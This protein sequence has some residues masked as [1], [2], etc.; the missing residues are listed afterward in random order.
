MQDF[1]HFSKDEFED[2]LKHFSEHLST[3]YNGSTAEYIYNI[4]T[5]KNDIIIYV[6]SS[7]SIA[8]G[9]SRS[10][11]MDAI[12]CVLFDLSTNQPLGKE[13]RTHRRLGWEDRLKAKIEDL[14]FYSDHLKYCEKCSSVMRIKKG[15]YGD[16]WGCIRYPNCN[17]TC[18]N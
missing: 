16:F 2:F 15:K 18:K 9:I 1:I 4:P 11:G 7:I 12:R 14:L 13:K 6:Y 3:T 5:R 17:Y 8:K 10:K